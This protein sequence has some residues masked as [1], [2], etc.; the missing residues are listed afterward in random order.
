MDHGGF[1]KGDSLGVGKADES[2]ARDDGVLAAGKFFEHVTGVVRG[3]RLAE[4]VALEGDFGVGADDN[5]RA[6]GARGDEFGF[7][8]GQT[9]NEVVGG[10]AGVGSLVDRGGENGEGETGVVEDFGAADGS[11]SE[12]EFHAGFLVR[13]I[14]QRQG[15]NCLCFGPAEEAGNL[16]RCRAREQGVVF[17]RER[18]AG[19]LGGNFLCFRDLPGKSARD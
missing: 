18:S 16:S 5:G 17:R 9:L 10:F 13:R 6:N 14:L 2:D 11:G 1:Y 8:E 7:G 19:F 3:A 4:D 12:N 15:G